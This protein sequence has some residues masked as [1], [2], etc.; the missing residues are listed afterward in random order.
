MFAPKIIAFHTPA[1]LFEEDQRAA[2]SESALL[3]LSRSCLRATRYGIDGFCLEF[4]PRQ[5]TKE[6]LSAVLSKV[7]P[8]F[9]IGLALRLAEP[10]EIEE[11]EGAVRNLTPYLSSSSV[12]TLK[13]KPLLVVRFLRPDLAEAFRGTSPLK[14]PGGGN[15]SLVHMG[16]PPFSEECDE[17]R[18]IDLSS[19][20][21]LSQFEVGPSDRPSEHAQNSISYFDYVRLSHWARSERGWQPEVIPTVLLCPSKLLPSHYDDSSAVWRGVRSTP[22][23]FQQWL[24]DEIVS[25][26]NRTTCN[27][28]LVFL[29]YPDSREW[30][31]SGATEPEWINQY[32]LAIS[33]AKRGAA[34]LDEQ[35]ST[36]AFGSSPYTAE[37]R[38]VLIEALRTLEDQRRAIDFL[39]AL[40]ERPTIPD[41]SRPSAKRTIAEGAEPLRW[42]QRWGR[43]VESLVPGRILDFGRSR[44]VLFGAGGGGAAAL[45]FLP[46]RYRVIAIADSSP[47]RQGQRMGGVPVVSP[48]R[49]R[50]LDFD[51]VAITSV[52]QKVMLA[53]LIGLGI[54]REKIIPHWQSLLLAR[55]N[56]ERTLSDQLERTSE[57]CGLALE[58]ARAEH[59]ALAQSISK[60]WETGGLP[61]PDPEQRRASCGYADPNVF[62]DRGLERAGYA[63][64]IILKQVAEISP[65]QIP[66]API[67][68]WECGCALALRWL[69]N[70]SETKELPLEG[71]DS[72]EAVQAW[73][74][75]AGERRVR[76]VVGG[77]LPYRDESI[78]LL[79]TFDAFMGIPENQFRSRLN[80]A[81]RVLRPGGILHFF[82]AGEEI[83]AAY[84]QYA[85]PDEVVRHFKAHGWGFLE[86]PGIKNSILLVAPHWVRAAVSGQ[87]KVTCNQSAYRSLDY[88]TVTKGGA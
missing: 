9:K 49:L 87:S 67:V 33:L 31:L 16:S 3:Q 25:L 72:S 80:E 44:L 27:E 10:K 75:N 77:T 58:V 55:E 35:L 64:A 82:S 5:I 14:P 63:G 84:Q 4:S 78:G 83:A 15:V 52:H 36:M 37:Q 7:P 17:G 43:V 45:Q 1:L 12:L 79:F 57:D 56:L 47:D 6:I 76:G 60:V 29:Q 19:P 23:R 30:H 11:F 48:Q 20:S 73:A 2:P 38:V 34:G 61:F 65:G 50:E 53:Q 13:G 41:M 74:V 68:E 51:L 46:S 26:R 71:C 18:L 59:T 24:Q 69:W 62:L 21:I 85:V 39:S 81:L 42:F 32:L 86:R 22:I 70:S 54:P 40:F 66:Q 28:G 88:Y 8:A